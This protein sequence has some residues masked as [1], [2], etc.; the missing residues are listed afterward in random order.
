MTDG[1]R[2]LFFLTLCASIALPLA[3]RDRRE[4]AWYKGNTHTQTLWSDGDA[5]P[6]FAADWYKS[7]GYH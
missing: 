4:G 3:A 1:V 6:E 7:H 5:A 2:S